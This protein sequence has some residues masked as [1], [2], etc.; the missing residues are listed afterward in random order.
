[1]LSVGSAAVPYRL[2]LP[3]SED[4]E[5]MFSNLDTDPDELNPLHGWSLEELI[6]HVQRK[7]GDEAGKWLS[8]AEKVGKW[9]IEEQK[10][11]WNY[12]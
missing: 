12:Q 5:Y 10:R 3:L 6:G 2:I 7:H 9:W 1:M 8:D 4:F 11:L